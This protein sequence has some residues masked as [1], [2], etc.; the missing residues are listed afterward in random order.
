MSNRLRKRNAGF[1]PSCKFLHGR[2]SVDTKPKHTVK[3]REGGSNYLQLH[4]SLCTL[5]ISVYEECKLPFDSKNV[6][7]DRKAQTSYSFH[8]P[9]HIPLQP[10]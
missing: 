7:T 5:Y 8:D 4:N 10:L 9:E 2:D 1:K 3:T 6:I